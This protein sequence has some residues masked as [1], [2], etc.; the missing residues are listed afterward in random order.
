MEQTCF[1]ILF[2]DGAFCIFPIL[3]GTKNQKII[4]TIIAN[5]DQRYRNQNI[6]DYNQNLESP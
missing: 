1:Y 6:T 4:T 3:L 2:S 5:A